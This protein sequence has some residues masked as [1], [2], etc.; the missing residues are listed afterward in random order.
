VYIETF[1]SQLLPINLLFE[2]KPFYL[3]EYFQFPKTV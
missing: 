2:A 1:R 3:C